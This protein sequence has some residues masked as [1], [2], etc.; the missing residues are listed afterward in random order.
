V[1]TRYIFI[2]VIA[3]QASSGWSQTAL[4]E[5]IVTAQKR[6]QALSEVPL[7]VS[8]VSP[9]RLRAGGIDRIG[10]LTE[11][12][13]N[14]A[15]TETGLST[16]LYV[17]GIGSG[18][19][20]AFEQ[21]VGQY[22]DG[23]QYSRQPLLRAP[24][25]DLARVEVL[26]GPQGTLFG[27]SSI[28]GALNL[29]TVRPTRERE[30]SV[31]ALH[32]ASAGQRELTAIAS[33]PLNA[34]LLARFAYR[35]HRETGYVENT[36]KQRDEP[37]RDEDTT[38]LTLLWE[39]TSALNASFK[40]ERGA[41]DTLGRQIEI[42]RDDPNASGL[43]LDQILRSL[44]QPGID[45]SADLRRQVDAEE[46]S[47]S[48]Y[49]NAT[50]TFD[51]ALG[52]YTLSA[53]SGRVAYDFQEQCDC[54]YSGADL[55]HARLG[56][57]YAQ[58]SQELRLTAPAARRWS[59]MVG[60]HAQGTRFSSF[61]SIGVPYD[62]PLGI[63]AAALP[64]TEPLRRNRQRGAAWAG[65]AQ[66]SRQLRDTVRLTLGGR[67]TQER[68][69]A[70]RTLDIQ[71]LG[72]QAPVPDPRA[73]LL[74]YSAFGMYS[75]QLAGLSVAPD[76]T[77]P[78]HDLSGQRSERQFTPA[79]T[80]E[81]DAPANVLLYASAS[82]GFKGGGFDARA[83]NP[84]S[85]E[86]APEHATAF[87]LGAKGR[88]YGGALEV[89]AALYVTHYENLQVSQFDGALGFNVGNARATRV[90]GMELDGR[91]AASDTLTLSYAYAYLDFEFT[92]FQGGNCYNRQLP[93]GL[94]VNGVAL[95]DYSGKRGQYA[96]RHSASLS[97]DHHLP[98]RGGLELVSSA[99][100]N[101]RGAA[102]LHENLDPSMRGAAFTLFNARVA[103]EGAA[104]HVAL[105]GKNLSD[106]SVLTYA[107][108]VPLS[109]SVF[110]T[111]TFYALSERGRQFA[112]EMG[113][114][115]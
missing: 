2:P 97:L 26:R 24:F 103:L 112:V 74:Y 53:I 92:D 79:L 37:Q 61:E 15:M 36:F 54:D 96:P 13:P 105:V 16:Q 81:W 21:S 43:N 25:L 111:N 32:E 48:R 31:S 23:I 50:L 102:N 30:L 33:G 91:W 110:G 83:N 19:N 46:F 109:A 113:V 17:R 114:R 6:E 55:F 4:E 38:R 84:F 62:S 35:G 9:A 40:L 85:F 90:A 28:A 45:G 93:D 22:V 41:F 52:D 47:H 66:I 10:D 49:D 115:F 107:A 65:F 95:C 59:W 77:L 44:G 57:A 78:G 80:L 5:I 56:E 75:R 7:S 1:N 34:G 73:P 87:E 68:K 70:T 99:M 69:S 100:L 106:A 86:F 76:V 82:R 58:W 14:L 89:N 94:V 3:L 42:V 60:L 63:F 18:N 12:V 8:V 20:Q 104:W 51:Y 29:T 88:H 108:N 11:F 64:G 27:K 101:H 67:Y 71:A 39:A 98:L 72:T